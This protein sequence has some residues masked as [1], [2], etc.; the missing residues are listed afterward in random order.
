M[1][2]AEVY[3][4]IFNLHVTLPKYKAILYW[5]VR[6]IFNDTG[7]RESNVYVSYYLQMNHSLPVLTGFFFP[8]SEKPKDNSHYTILYFKYFHNPT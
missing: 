8:F 2:T 4:Q 5:I 3:L 6:N 7:K 1:S